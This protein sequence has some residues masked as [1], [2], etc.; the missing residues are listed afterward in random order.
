MHTTWKI[1]QQ[2]NWVRTH[3]SYQVTF[4]AK[5]VLC[6]HQWHGFEVVIFG[7]LGLCRRGG[8]TKLKPQHSNP[9]SPAKAAADAVAIVLAAIGTIGVPA[10]ALSIRIRS[11]NRTR[12]TGFRG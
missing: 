10:P 3:L 7:V 11:R 1:I 8:G 2:S 4:A 6:Q 12:A 9:K 5:A